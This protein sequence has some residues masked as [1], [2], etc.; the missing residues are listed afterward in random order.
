MT[1]RMKVVVGAVVVDRL[2][3]PTKVLAT[4]RA[5]GP[6]S[7]LWEFPGGKVEDGEEPLAALRRELDEELGL[8]RVRF[9]DQVPG[10]E[11]DGGWPITH[12]WSLRV[13]LTEVD[14]EVSPGPAHDLVQWRELPELADLD[15]LPADVPIVR[16][17]QRVLGE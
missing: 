12:G 5:H 10:P 17:V 15:W 14:H 3:A 2:D 16:E 8:T 7:G 13:W 9:G 1:R 6:L 4:R 11:R